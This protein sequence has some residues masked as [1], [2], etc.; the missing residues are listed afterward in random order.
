MNKCNIILYYIT[1]YNIVNYKNNTLLQLYYTSIHFFFFILGEENRIES[2]HK[3]LRTAVL[4][5]LSVFRK[6]SLLKFQNVNEICKDLVTPNL[7]AIRSRMLVNRKNM[8]TSKKII[9]I[10]HLESTVVCRF[11]LEIPNLLQYFPY[12][13]IAKANLLNDSQQQTV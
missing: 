2:S 7:A 4:T 1:L 6:K 10:I 9:S 5:C 3:S 13:L 11:N 12:L 8:P